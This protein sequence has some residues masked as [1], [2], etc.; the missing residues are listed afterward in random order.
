MPRTMLRYAIEKLPEKERLAFLQGTN[1]TSNKP[2]AF[3][4]VVTRGI[5]KRM[6]FRDIKTG[7]T[8]WTDRGRAPIHRLAAY[9]LPSGFIASR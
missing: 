3:H 5:E 7:N 2:G 4:N 6:I 1:S 9:V 8:S